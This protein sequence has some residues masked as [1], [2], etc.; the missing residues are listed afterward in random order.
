MR[1]SQGEIELTKDEVIYLWEKE[2]GCPMPDE[3][4][5]QSAAEAVLLVYGAEMIERELHEKER[6]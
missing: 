6:C 2:W 4:G 5:L 1:R 3:L